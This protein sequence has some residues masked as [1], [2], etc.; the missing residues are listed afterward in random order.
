MARSLSLVLLGFILAASAQAQDAVAYPNPLTGATLTV[1]HAP[2]AATFELYD[3]LGRRLDARAHHAAGVYLWRLRLADGTRTPAQH[4]TRLTSGTMDVQMLRTPTSAV[5]APAS[6][7]N[8]RE[9]PEG[10]CRIADPVFGGFQHQPRRGS[11]LSFSPGT[12]TVT[13]GPG[14]ASVQTC[15]GAVGGVGYQFPTGGSPWSWG[16]SNST[17]FTTVSVVTV[18]TGGDGPTTEVPVTLKGVDGIGGDL[19][20]QFDKSTPKI[21]EVLRYNPDGTTS[22]VASATIPAG[23]PETRRV[24][25][26]TT[27]GGATGMEMAAF[28]ATGGRS[29]G[30]AY[31]DSLATVRVDMRATGPGF[32]LVNIPGATVQGD[33]VQVSQFRPEPTVP[34]YLTYI[35]KDFGAGAPSFTIDDLGF[36]GETE[37]NSPTPFAPSFAALPLNAYLAWLR[38]VDPDNQIR[39][40]IDG[41]GSEIRCKRGGTCATYGIAATAEFATDAPAEGFT[42]GDMTTGPGRGLLYNPQKRLSTLAAYTLTSTSGATTPGDL[43]LD[44]FTQAT[45]SLK[46]RYRDTGATPTVTGG[47]VRYIRDGIMRRQFAL[48]DNQ[49]VDLGIRVE[50]SDAEVSIDTSSGSPEMVFRYVDSFRPNSEIEV[51]WSFGANNAGALYEMIKVTYTNPWS[52]ETSLWNQ[53]PSN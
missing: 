4:L 47:E 52:F 17:S 16:E 20:A 25:R 12:M 11:T 8:A 48:A 42:V 45:I 29:D 5:A 43:R 41:S 26:F 24:A 49:T 51:R 9:L 28:T 34:S 18:P 22:V 44:L 7:A 33:A 3:L 35:M 19:R 40:A 32:L 27:G 2:Q 39:P 50:L 38:V 46:V 31:L 14:D 6:A 13:A 1:E 10:Q 23:T 36:I 21:V 15:L 53:A 37:K 30:T